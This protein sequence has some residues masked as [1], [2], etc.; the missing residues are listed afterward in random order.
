MTCWFSTM[1]WISDMSVAGSPPLSATNNLI[2]LPNT[3][4]W[5]FTQAAQ[6]PNASFAG[7]NAAPTTPLKSPTS[8][9][10]TGAVLAFGVPDPL[11]PEPATVRR[12]TAAEFEPVAG[13]PPPPAPAVAE[14]PPPISEGEPLW[15]SPDDAPERV[16]EP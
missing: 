11:A 7:A 4:P 13:E 8:P 12:D 2:G 1:L 6:A 15:P 14:G 10:S 3:P 16:D 9:T 5:A